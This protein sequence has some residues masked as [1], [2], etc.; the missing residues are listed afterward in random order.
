MEERVYNNRIQII[1]H[2]ARYASKIP[3]YN[4]I[5]NGNA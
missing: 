5:N 4:R 2:S 3:I 1:T